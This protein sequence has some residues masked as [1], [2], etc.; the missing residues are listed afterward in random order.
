M[1]AIQ[2]KKKH[3]K[4]ILYEYNNWNVNDNVLD[5]IVEKIILIQK[6]V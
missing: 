2:K 1:V 3:M 4:N 6:L 5:Q